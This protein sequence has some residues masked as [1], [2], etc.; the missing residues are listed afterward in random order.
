M[1]CNSDTVYGPL[2]SLFVGDFDD[3]MD[4]CASY[5]YYTAS[6]FSNGTLVNQTCAAVS[7]VPL[8]TNRTAAFIGGAPGNC[9]LKPGPQNRTALYTPN[10]G[11]ECH[12]A[13]LETS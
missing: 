13:I 6:D 5:S 12:S 4:A 3:C 10:I 8:W 7:F 1:Y 2:M 11:T 9:Y